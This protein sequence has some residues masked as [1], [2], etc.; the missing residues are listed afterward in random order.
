MEEFTPPDRSSAE[1]IAV[2]RPFDDLD[3]HP[4]LLKGLHDAGFIRCTPIQERSLPLTLK[5]KDIAAQAQTGTGKTAVFLITIFQRLISDSTRSKEKGQALVLAPTRELALQIYHDA[6][7]LGRHLPFRFAMI[8]G[9]VAYQ[10]Q[11]DEL[12]AGPNLVIATPGRLIDF[13]KQGMFIPHKCSI[14]VIDEAD[15]MLD[16]GFIADLR[17]ILRRLPPYTRRQS[18]L[19]SAT[20]NPRVLEL[21]YEYMN[22]PEE[23]IENP[24]APLVEKIEQVLYHVGRG[25][26]FSLLLGLLKREKSDRVMIFANTK[27]QVT[28]LAERLK[29]NGYHAVDLTGDLR[30]SRRTFIVDQFK[31]GKIGILVATDVASRGIHVDDV[32]HVIN[33][34]VPQDREDYIHRVGRTARAGKAGKAIT[35]A[36]EDDVHFLEPIE[37]LLGEKIPLE[38]PEDDWF[39]PDTSPRERPSRTRPRYYGERKKRDN[40]T[41]VPPPAQPKSTRSK[42]RPPRKKKR[43]SSEDSQKSV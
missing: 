28:R 29:S 8:Y 43:K 5:G 32:S 17:Y 2:G 24:E 25:E 21:S 34:D 42:K 15:R 7:L 38:W 4:D 11:T 9:G 16:M 19:F 12:K 35:L 23:I 33:Y 41:P 26:K 10:R 27:A 18:M 40:R 1:P 6:K 3:L 31:E 22:N 14:L 30:Q 39:I 13:I 37:K 36:S 20:L